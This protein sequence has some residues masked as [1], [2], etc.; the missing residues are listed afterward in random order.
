MPGS[1][2]LAAPFV[3][4]FSR[5]GRAAG[6][7]SVAPAQFSPAAGTMEGSWT[8]R[9]TDAAPAGEMPAAISAA[10]AVMTRV[11]YKKRRGCEMTRLASELGFMV[12]LLH[13]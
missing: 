12:A 13:S 10:E 7:I 8:D 4:E 2:S 1:T 9:P 3:V 6:L 5:K 11:K